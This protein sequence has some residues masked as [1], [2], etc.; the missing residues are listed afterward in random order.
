MAIAVKCGQCFRGF[1]VKDH[2]AGL[3]G[4]CP[5]CRYT[6]VVPDKRPEPVHV[7]ADSIEV[8]Y[9]T[10]HAS[11]ET[12]TSSISLVTRVPKMPCQ[13]CD[14]PNL[15]GSATCYYCGVSLLD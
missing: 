6:V 9:E 1:K 11:G 3:S 13:A 8:R 4:M 5:Y 10:R 7:L 14:K 2:Y 15:V 12:S